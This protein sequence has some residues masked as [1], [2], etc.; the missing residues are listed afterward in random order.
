MVSLAPL[1]GEQWKRII[2]LPSTAQR[3]SCLPARERT[4][5]RYSSK[6]ATARGG[7]R[8]LNSLSIF[9]G[10]VPPVCDQLDANMISTTR[11]DECP[12][13]TSVRVA[14]RDGGAAGGGGGGREGAAP[15]FLFSFRGG[16]G[17]CDGEMGVTLR[18]KA[19]STEEEDAQPRDLTQLIAI[20]D[21]DDDEGEDE[22]RPMVFCGASSPVYEL[23]SCRV[24][25][26]RTTGGNLPKGKGGRSR[27]NDA[28]GGR[29]RLPTTGAPAPV[30]PRREGQSWAGRETGGISQGSTNFQHYAR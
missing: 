19:S 14:N 9:P 29:R 18:Q 26:G 6:S 15:T 21:D 24:S 3:G 11:L 12:S 23:L 10:A 8:T 28:G 4:A 20:D 22:R 2:S 1:A 5:S 17:G 25:R 16:Q 27:G 13:G 7:W 30:Q